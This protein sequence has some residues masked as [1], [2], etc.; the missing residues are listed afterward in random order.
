MATLA[1]E[2]LADLMGSDEEGEGEERDDDF[3]QQYAGMDPSDGLMK[4]DDGTSEEDDEDEEEKFIKA[5]AELA[6]KAGEED[7][8]EVK[9]KVEKMDFGAI[10]DVRSVA[11]LMKSLKP[12]IEVSETPSQPSARSSRFTRARG[13]ALTCSVLQKIDFYQKPE[14]QTPNIGSIEDNPEYRLLTQANSLSTSID[15]EIILVH[16]FIR[17]HY[18]IRFPELERLIE[19]ALQYAKTVAI[20]GNGPMEDLGRVIASTDNVTGQTLAEVLDGPRLMSVRMEASTSKG[21]TLSEKELQNVIRAC[22]MTVQLDSAKKILTD[23]VQS[24]MN[25]FAPNLTVLVGSETAAKLVNTSGGLAGLAKTP[26]CNIAN[27]GWNSRATGLATNVGVRQ[28]GYL[29]HSPILQYVP[30]DL[31]KQAMRIVAAKVVLAARVDQT[32]KTPDNSMG[33]RLKDECQ[34]RLD[35]LTEPPPNKGP[36]ALPAPDDKPARKRGGRRA[37]EA[38]KQF[39]QTDLRKEQNRMQFGKEEAE[40]GFGVGDSTKGLGMIGASNDGRVRATQ[41]DKKTAARLSKKNPGW[42]AATPVGGLASS[43]RGFGQ[44]AGAGAASMGLRT[45]GVGTTGTASIV[46]FTPVQGLELLNPKAKQEA[47]RKRKAEEDRWFNN[48][49]FTQVGGGAM[50]PPPPKV[51]SSGFKVPALP[52]LKKHK[53]EGK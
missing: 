29:F 23:Y 18:S 45:A 7:E 51:D 2:L 37:R 1:D 3:R 46:A 30:N 50:A 44:G 38:K 42:G 32:L 15:S 10:S 11:G 40:T 4:D 47:D 14:N 48:G 20:I 36:R 13:T 25:L 8:E 21:R 16:K 31:K 28:K 33:Q 39:A 9:V 49:T 17:D 6:K 26:S 22:E 52:A 34:E 41:I 27:M 24:R 35:K 43:M 5:A 53:V 12:V 19:N